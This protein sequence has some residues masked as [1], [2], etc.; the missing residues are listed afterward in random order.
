MILERGF[1]RS[2][3][4]Q[5]DSIS[6]LLPI[7]KKVKIPCPLRTKDSL[8][9]AATASFSG[10]SSPTLFCKRVSTTNYVNCFLENEF[11]VFKIFLFRAEI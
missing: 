2:L 11:H 3:R 4:L 6:R 8:A 10:S 5:E 7:Y 9:H 1:Y